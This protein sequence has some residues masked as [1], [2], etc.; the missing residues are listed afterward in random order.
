[1]G[2]IRRQCDKN[3][4]TLRIMMFWSAP[5]SEAQSQRHPFEQFWGLQQLRRGIVKHVGRIPPVM[6]T[7]HGTAT[8]L[9]HL[10]LQRIQ[11]KHY[12]WYAEITAG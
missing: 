9:E 7:D 5:L 1:M 12:R 6:Y 8:R 2:G 10:P 11:A 4:G 3:E